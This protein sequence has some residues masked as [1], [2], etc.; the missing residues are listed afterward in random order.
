MNFLTPRDRAFILALPQGVTVSFETF[1]PERSAQILASVNT[2]NRPI[3]ERFLAQYVRAMIEGWVWNG[4]TIVFDY[5]GVL[6]NGQHRLKASVGSERP[7]TSL[8]VRGV[9]PEVQ[10]SQDNLLPRKATHQLA[11][12]KIVH[13]FTVAATARMYYLSINWPVGSQSTLSNI[14][15]VK[16]VT[17]HPGLSEACTEVRSGY[18]KLT[19]PYTQTALWRYM[20]SQAADPEV[21]AA[22]D[23]AW[24][25]LRTGVPSYE[26]DPIHLFRER[27]L[28]GAAPKHR[29]TMTRMQILW[30]LYGAFDAFREHGTLKK[31]MWRTDRY[32]MKGSARW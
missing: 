22:G 19:L 1:P 29:N 17:E 26:D 20:T 24:E 8:V 4:D 28:A 2:H 12:M 7:F 3:Q 13:S 15:I 9:P 30:T 27:Y 25:V 10:V 32:D 6:L 11:L 21:R 14:E 23:A 18:G 16:I 31:I 5:N